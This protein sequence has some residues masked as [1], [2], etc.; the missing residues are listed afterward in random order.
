MSVSSTGDAYT[1]VLL[2]PDHLAD[3]YGETFIQSTIALYPRMG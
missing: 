2:Y 3:W 1:V